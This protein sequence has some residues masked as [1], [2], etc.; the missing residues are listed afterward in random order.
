MIFLAL[1]IAAYRISLRGPGAELEGGV[2]R[3]L[4]SPALHGKHRSPAR[5]GLYEDIL[6][7]EFLVTKR[8]I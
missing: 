5:R 6:P 4:P 3:P 1:S 8:V 2:K 7:N